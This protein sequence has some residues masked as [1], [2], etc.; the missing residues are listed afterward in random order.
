MVGP[1]VLHTIADV[2]TNIALPILVGAGTTVVSEEIKEWRKKC[3]VE[4]KPAIEPPQ[5]L[6]EELARILEARGGIAITNDE[7]DAAVVAVS[8]Y[9]SQ[10]GWPRM[11]AKSDAA[12]IIEVIRQH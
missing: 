7:V 6:Q 4:H 2:V 12:Q 1:E 3:E 10:R 9:L 5:E 8:E 11:F